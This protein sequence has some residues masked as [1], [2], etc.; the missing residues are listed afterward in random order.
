[1]ELTFCQSGED[2]ESVLVW[3]GLVFFWRGGAGEAGHST[4]PNEDTY[5]GIRPVTPAFRKEAGVGD[6]DVLMPLYRWFLRL[7]IEEI[8]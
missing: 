4:Y 5:Y 1:V 3:F 6:E 8:T 2:H 7:N